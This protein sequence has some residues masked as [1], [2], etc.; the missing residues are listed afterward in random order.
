MEEP[1]GRRPL[2]AGGDSVL[3]QP[4][5]NPAAPFRVRALAEDAAPERSVAGEAGGVRPEDILAPLFLHPG[6][7]PLVIEQ[8]FLVAAFLIPEERDRLLRLGEPQGVRL[9][10]Q[11]VPR[12]AR[13]RRFRHPLLQGIEPRQRDLVDLLVRPVTLLDDPVGDQPPL[14]QPGELGVDLAVPGLP[15]KCPLSLIR[16]VRSYPESS[17]RESNPKIAYPSVAM[18]L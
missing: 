7:P 4:V 3:F 17:S 18:Y 9:E 14:L 6:P 1:V 5:R 16:P 10:D 13:R 2:F 8:P 12:G 11:L 15:E